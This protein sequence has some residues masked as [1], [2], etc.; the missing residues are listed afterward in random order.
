ML[1]V[2]TPEA[3]RA[4]RER[5]QSSQ[6]AIGFDTESSGPPLANGFLNVYKSTLTGFSVSFLNGDSYYVPVAHDGGGNVRM[7]DRYALLMAVVAHKGPVYIHNLK[8]E[9]KVLGLEG[10]THKQLYASNLLCTQ[11]LMWLLQ[12]PAEG[13]S[14]YGLKALTKHHFGY[15]MTTFDTVSKGGLFSALDPSENATLQYACD[16]AIYS[17]KLGSTYHSQL[18]P[19]LEKTYVTHERKFTHVL[20]YMEDCGF[21]VDVDALNALKDDL[22]PRLDAIDS[23]LDFIMPGVNI[24]SS[25]QLREWGWGKGRWPLVDGLDLTPKS[26]L[27]STN[28]ANMEKMDGECAEG[29]EGALAIQ[30]LLER[31]EFQK[32]LSTYTT[33]LIEKAQEYDDCR[34]R[35]SYNQT[36]TNTGRLA[37][38][39]PNLMAVP[40]RT[41]LGK[42][43][44]DALV[45]A[46]GCTLVSADFSQIDLRVLAHLC[47]G[48]GKLAEAYFEKKDIHQQTADLA[49]CTRAQG[50]TMNFLV[51]FG[52]QG[53]KL[54]KGLKCT[55]PEANKYLENF[56]AGYP[57]V[58]EMG[59][60]VVDAVR[61]RGYVKT[62][63][64]RR[65]YIPEITAHD[66]STR[67][68][69]ERIARNTPVQGGTGDV[70]M[71]G[72]IRFFEAI[73]AANQEGVVKIVA[74][75]HDDLVCEAPEGVGGHWAKV[76][77]E[78]LV[79][80]YP[81]RVPLVAESVI[82]T[83]W[84][85]HKT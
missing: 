58:V 8:H 33:S 68:H 44:R 79:G 47:G 61:D 12:K 51:V 63:L 81:L 77:E 62:L 73:M 17:L 9:L 36:G 35:T 19:V 6:E 72:M 83:P 23:E 3:V 20:R 24:N 54:A 64:G 39:E 10:F 65:R 15:D 4:L 38:S 74:Q 55:L 2:K 28:H 5:L 1:L 71:L 14:Q 37:G 45:S 16:D 53:K 27:P 43:V 18:D 34:L 42:R 30:L 40:V 67:W 76:L 31:A 66:R 59:K 41:P 84:S 21:A 80:A 26:K 50:K 75:V 22:Q 60:R 52:G 29:S 78:S 70:M 48:K 82:G 13:K 32:L 49:G 25:V 85:K 69:A 57:E 11:V 56:N 7:G 46:P